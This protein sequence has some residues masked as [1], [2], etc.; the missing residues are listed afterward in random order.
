M[1]SKHQAA[2]KR[3][4]KAKFKGKYPGPDK[5]KGKKPYKGKYPGP[6]KYKGKPPPK[7][8][9]AKKAP[10]KK[11]APKPVNPNLPA[12]T[13][14]APASDSNGNLVFQTNF[15]IE[16]ATIDAQQERQQALEDANAMEGES[17]VSETVGKQNA[18]NSDIDNR[19]KTAGYMASRGMR[20]SAAM[21]A[22]ANNKQAYSDNMS[23]I[24]MRRQQEH[25][26][27]ENM[28]TGANARFKQREASLI[29]AKKDFTDSQSKDNPTI[30]A[31]P[32]NSDIVP[33]KATPVAVKAA[34]K[35]A[36]AKPPAKKKFKGKYPGPDKYK[37]KKPYKGK[38]PGPG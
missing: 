21:A 10:A 9:P 6:D 7:K 18:L 25:A 13:G 3:K 36:V 1:A 2:A 26:T 19:T 15:D 14:V 29:Q 38:R 31:P 32:V 35:R 37:G 28:K 8:A 27:S 20:G 22:S 24:A 12:N 34:A 11:P 33:P 30:G 17:L 23:Q 16:K 5:Y 4:V